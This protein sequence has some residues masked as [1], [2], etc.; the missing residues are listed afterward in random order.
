[1]LANVFFPISATFVLTVTVIMPAFR[2]VR[3][4]GPRTA[5]SNWF[6]FVCSFG[7]IRALTNGVLLESTVKG[8]ASMP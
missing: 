2:L 6:L 8:Q 1:M 5:Q 4:V 7:L 3:K